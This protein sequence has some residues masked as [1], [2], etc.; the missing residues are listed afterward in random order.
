MMKKFALL[1]VFLFL[2]TSLFAQKNSSEGQDNY[3]YKRGVELL[4]NADVDGALNYFSQAIEQEPTNGYAWAWLGSIH[5]LYPTNPDYKLAN[6]CFNN[7]LLYLPTK[8]KSIRVKT[9]LFVSRLHIDCGSLNTAY[10]YLLEA[11]KLDKKNPAIYAQLG[12]LYYQSNDLENSD[13]CY[14]TAK[15]YD[16]NDPSLDLG[17]A[18]NALACNNIPLGLDILNDIIDVYDNYA[19]AYVYRSCANFYMHNFEAGASD[20]L[21][22][23]SFGPSE[24]AFDALKSL[25]GEESEAVQLA[26]KKQ[27]SLEPNEPR[28]KYLLAV[29]AEVNGQTQKALDNYFQLSEQQVDM[30]LSSDIARCYFDMGDFENSIPYCTRALTADS[31]KVE[32]LHRRAWAY[33]ETN[34][35]DSAY[36][37]LTDLLKKLP[38][39]PDAHYALALFYLRTDRQEEALKEFS[40]S[41]MYDST[42]AVAFLLRGEIYYNMGENEKARRD[43]LSAI[44]YDRKIFAGNVSQFAYFYI[45]NLNEAVKIQNEILNVNGNDEEVLLDAARFYAL[46]GDNDKCINYL[47]ASINA[48]FH[49]KQFVARD[50]VFAKV[51]LLPEFDSLW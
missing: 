28:W 12:E 26:L 9:L 23:F 50:P 3:F 20:L 5:Y 35:I 31:T 11:Q 30:D 45:G 47:R 14:K 4:E 17:L 24:K 1:F 13:N 38:E 21:I 7:A 18:R 10:S 33:F 15:K 2:M 49:R 44:K 8:D 40:T 6:L 39:A 22:A 27:I 46:L 32:S 42:S 16:K 43:F 41:I 37:D 51:R 19:L 29:A 48:G 34:K 25:R 36:N